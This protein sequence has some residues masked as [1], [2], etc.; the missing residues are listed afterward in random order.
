MKKLINWSIFYFLFLI[1][2]INQGITK[3]KEILFKDINLFNLGLKLETNYSFSENNK[4]K[5][6]NRF[7]KLSKKKNSEKYLLE[8]KNFKIIRMITFEKNKINISDKYYNKSKKIIGIISRYNF[9]NNLDSSYI[10]SGQQIDKNEKFYDLI[11]ENPTLIFRSQNISYGLYFNDFYS[12]INTKIK[13]NSNNELLLMNDNL[14]LKPGE[15]YRKDFDVYLFKKDLEYFSFVNFLRKKLNVYSKIEGNF[16]LI[17]TYRNKEVLKNKKKLRSFFK[18]YNVKFLL[19][20]PWLDYTDFNFNTNKRYSRTEIINHFKKIKEDIKKIDPNIKLLIP[21]QS[22]IISLDYEVQNKLINNKNN[23]IKN[24]FHHYEINPNYLIK[25]SKLDLKKNELIYDRNNKIL[26]ETYYHD[27]KFGKKDIREIALPLK[28]YPNGHLYKKLKEQ[29]NFVIDKIEYDGFYIDQFN[30]YAISPKHKKS[31]DIS[32]LNAGIIDLNNGKIIEKF[33][34]ITL[35]T[36]EFE[37]KIIKFAKNKTKY[38]FFNTH[39]IHD[40][41][42]SEPVIRF[43]EGFWYFWADKMWE[44]NSREFYLAKTFFRSHLSTPVSLSL[45]TIQKGSWKKNPHLALVKNLRF[46]IFNGNLMYFLPQDIETLNINEK[47]LSV[48]EKIYPINIVTINQGLIKGINKI[49]SINDY[50]LTKKELSKYNIFIFDKNGYLIND[51]RGK[52]KNKN[53][54]VEIQLIENEEILVLEKK[55]K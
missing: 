23:N 52:L 44:E 36:R 43:A 27:W 46:C 42:R 19:L 14:I 24:N 39:H 25:K 34:N 1:S 16:F 17:D 11:G 45:G 10:F 31:Y 28:A 3:E 29:I 21:I 51:V 35:N 32:N 13:K 22:N 6:N 9:K 53:K 47:K 40:N 18:K 20:N 2:F 37:K 38:I 48:F 33:E 30:Q 4:I 5:W 12:K 26:F 8:N 50:K 7:I 55:I 41:L 54:Y 49:I 15:I